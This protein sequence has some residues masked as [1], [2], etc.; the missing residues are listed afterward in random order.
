MIE[1]APSVSMRP[2][3]ERARWGLLLAILCWPILLSVIVAV[4]GHQAGLPHNIGQL[5]RFL[6]LEFLLWG[7]VFVVGFYLSGITASQLRLKTR[8]PLRTIGFG[9]LWFFGIRISTTLILWVASRWLDHAELWS[10]EEK[11]AFFIDA[12]NITLHLTFSIIVFGIA[13]LIGGFTEELWRAGMLAG[14][15][16]L[17]PKL[18]VFPAIL[19]VSILFGSAHLYQGFF[20]MGNATLLGILLGLILVY[21]NSY[22]EAAIPHTLFDA[23]AFGVAITIMLNAHSFSSQI[24]YEA[25]QGDLPKVN[26]WLNMGGDI[27]ATIDAGKGW[28]GVSAL[29]SAAARSNSEMVRFLLSKGADVNMADRQGR[30]PLIVAS[31]QNQLHNIKLLLSNGASINWQDN[32]GFTAL[33]CAAEYNRIEAARLLIDSGA[34]LN[35]KDKEGQTPLAAATKWDYSALKDLLE[36]KGGK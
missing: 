15:K 14:M 3:P 12:K 20:G 36:Q 32:R 17:F 4:T 21:R 26:H 34:D 13:S 33:R 35:L 11:L 25:S 9:L 23:L 22:W 28:K 29:E 5:I 10:S 24:V 19:L 18:G 2:L 8:H 7:S 31:E 1:Q 30:T 16:V 6:F 27:N